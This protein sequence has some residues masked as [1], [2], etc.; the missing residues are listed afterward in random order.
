MKKRV[1]RGVASKSIDPGGRDGWIERRG[2]GW[3]GIKLRR[4]GDTDT[5]DE[6]RGGGAVRARLE[7]PFTK[8]STLFIIR[9]ISTS[10]VRPLCYALH[11]E[12]AAWTIVI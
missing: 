6:D 4:H 5:R 3:W 9:K 1:E 12:R 7:G 8:G 2:A 10:P 11:V